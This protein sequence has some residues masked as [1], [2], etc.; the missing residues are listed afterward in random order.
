MTETLAFTTPLDSDAGAGTSGTRAPRG[1]ASLRVLL[2]A[3]EPFS[4]PRGTPLNVIQMCRALT[5]AGHRVD[6][7]TYPLGRPAEMERLTVHP[8]YRVPGIHWVGIGFSGRKV[9]LDV[10]L[11]LKVWQLLASRRYD[12][13]HA[14]EE[15]VFFALPAARLARLPLIYDLD[16][17]ISHQLEY[18]D[19][20]RNRL[21]LRLIRRA[22]AI[23]LRRSS[24]A[25]TVSTS[26]TRFA[27]ELSPG[28]PVVQIEDTPVEESTRP[29]DM[30]R[31]AELRRG[32]GV[33][34]AACF[35]YTGN[36]E[37][38]QGVRHLLQAVPL[39]LAEAPAARFLFVGGDAAGVEALRRE[40]RALGVTHAVVF[41]GRRP[42]NEM[43]EYMALATALVSPRS[44]GHNTPLK[45]YTYMR[46][47]RPIVASDREA[48]TQVLDAGMAVLV[49]ATPRGL[50]DGMLRVLRDPA[51]SD[52]LGA[53]ARACVEAR[54]CYP[55]FARK[56]LLAYS[57]VAPAAG[58]RTEAEAPPPG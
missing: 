45:I 41:T 55:E 54:Y 23:A 25:I 30:E 57:R 22:E 38:Y 11:A 8:G 48:H 4:E 49:P 19:V 10:F 2:I 40:A 27:H 1:S 24:L 28:T 42:A 52:R 7:A 47:G 3:P 44:E 51:G 35:V 56:L 37:N 5:A 46:S 29:P 14:V 26:L 9:A 21:L 33:G 36:L 17:S 20:V 58:S 43:P 34:E 53:A 32:L 31:V 6:L 15:S 13:V 16:S 50:A 12:V 18:T 39:V